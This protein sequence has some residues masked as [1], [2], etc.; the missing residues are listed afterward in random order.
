MDATSFNFLMNVLSIVNHGLVDV[1]LE[2]LGDL[3][4]QQRRVIQQRQEVFFS[5][6]DFCEC[7]CKGHVLVEEGNLEYGGMLLEL[8]GIHFSHFADAWSKL[9]PIYNH[10]F[11]GCILEL[12]RIQ[13]EIAVFC[14]NLNP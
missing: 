13:R 12:C 14:N 2:L 3:T 7:A 9:K 10:N 5:L 6:V 8:A 1:S 4:D 11:L